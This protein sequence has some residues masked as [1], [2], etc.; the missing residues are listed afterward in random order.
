MFIISNFHSYKDLTSQLMD[1]KKNNGL[2]KPKQLD[3]KEKKV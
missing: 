1:G 3:P 2:D